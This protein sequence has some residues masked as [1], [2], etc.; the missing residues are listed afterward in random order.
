MSTRGA[1]TAGFFSSARRL[2]LPLG[3]S[4]DPRAVRG[5]PI[6]MRVKAH[7]PQWPP[8]WVASLD[9]HYVPLVQFGIGCYERFLAGEGEVWLQT[10]AAVGRHLVAKQEDDG[11]WLNRDP[12]RHTFLLDAPWRCGMAQ[13]QAASLLV[14]LFLTT[15][16]LAFA[17]AARSALS[18][19]ARPRE[20]N[21]VCAL[22]DGAPWPEEYPTNPPSFVLNGAMF[23]WWGLRDVAVGLGDETAAVAF[24]AGVDALAA[25]LWRFDTGHWSLYCLYPLPIQSIA[26]S[27][28]HALHISQLQAMN[29]LA[30]RPEFTAMQKRWVTYFGSRRLRWV[31]FARKALFRLIIPRNRLL[32][33]RLP[34][35]QPSSGT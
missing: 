17:D 32:A 22:L 5:Y 8:E 15:D 26:S 30:P 9:G 3:P 14:R 1:G 28:Y 7:L 12:F 33:D 16:E 2:T 25:N 35:T 23:A 29:I 31:A 18:P 6:D 13:G 4:L 10:A 24:E 34:W 21:G 19:L 27:F 20:H 11:S